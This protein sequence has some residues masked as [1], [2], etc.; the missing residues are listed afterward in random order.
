MTQS[1]LSRSSTDP[2]PRVEPATGP[3][4]GPCNGADFPGPAMLQPDP[5]PASLDWMSRGACQGEDPELF[6]PIAM[7]G[8]A[9]QQVSVA[10]AICQSCA[11]RVAC[12][13]YGLQTS[14][15]GIWG[16]TTRE[17]RRAM[18]RARACLPPSAGRASP[19]GV[20]VNA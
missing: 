16:G 10:K 13:S 15:D 6:F 17:E 19:A 20:A 4:C 12:L 1:P 5:R 14:Q 8:P 11:V 9:L 7:T 3:P 18:R 2:P